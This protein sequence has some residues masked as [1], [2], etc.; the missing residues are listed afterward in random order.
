MREI[1]L[2]TE[3]TGLDP[4]DGHRMVEIGC[5]ELINH[6]PTGNTWHYYLHPERDI[7][8]ESTA[9]HGITNEKVKDAPTFAQVVGSFSDFI[10]GARLVIHNAE[11]DIKFLNY[12]MK[13]FG[14]PPIKL[15]DVVD[16]LLIA[17]K[18]FPGQPAN[19]DALCRRFNIDLS[20]R[21]FHGA[22]LD[23]QLL[24]DVYL[25]L[26]GGRQHGLELG[27]NS[28]SNS[29]S[30][31]NGSTAQVQKIERV[32]RPARSFPV[33][34]DEQN[35]HDQMVQKLKDAVWTQ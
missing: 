13:E 23:A 25:E 5:I 33:S 9:V 11:F 24:A 4:H 15:T 35:A 26:S 12:Q 31:K 7:P 17:R 30:I 34:A 20:G 27:Q 2:D 32:H 28:K 22:L 18:K 29:S 16:T 19:L 1:V 8:A 14:Y 21:E 3:T 10:S 6:I